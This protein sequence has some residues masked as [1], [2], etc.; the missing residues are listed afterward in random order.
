MIELEGVNEF[1]LVNFCS[2]KLLCISQ[3]CKRS[4]GDRME[5]NTD[6]IDRISKIIVDNILEALEYD[7]K[8]REFLLELTR[9]ASR[10]CIKMW[11]GEYNSC[12]EMETEFV[13]ASKR[14]WEKMREARGDEVFFEFLGYTFAL[15]S[16]LHDVWSGLYPSTY[17]I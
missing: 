7:P 2:Q 1:N 15:Q 16:F 8:N 11:E 4:R 12:Y 17:I 10:I 6:K 5:I 13:E 3:F 14:V 9:E